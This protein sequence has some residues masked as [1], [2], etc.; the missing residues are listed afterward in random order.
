SECAGN[1][2]TDPVRR[3]VP[4]EFAGEPRGQAYCLR[5][6]AVGCERPFSAPLT[7]V[8]VSGAEEERYCGIAQE[9]VTC[10][11]VSDLLRGRACPGGS[12]T[13]C[14]CPRDA[15]G[16]CTAPGQGG[17]C[18][19]IGGIANQCTYRC[20]ATPRCPD[21]YSCADQDPNFCE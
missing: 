14:G 7:A 20:G 8:S 15:D 13:E 1:D 18:R 2:A 16:N 5:R 11:A 17:L 21:D 4:M 10:E 3:C 19:L 12:D 6:E 9:S